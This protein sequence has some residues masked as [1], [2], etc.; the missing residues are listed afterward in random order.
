MVWVTGTSSPEAGWLNVPAVRPGRS[1]RLAGHEG[2]EEVHHRSCPARHGARLCRRHYRSGRPPRQD[3]RQPGRRKALSI[4]SP[5]ARHRAALELVCRRDSRDGNRRVA[6]RRVEEA[7]D[8]VWA[9]V[10]E[11]RRI[12]HEGLA[13]FVAEDHDDGSRSA[14]A[15]TDKFDMGGRLARILDLGRDRSPACERLA[16]RNLQDAWPAA[17]ALALACR[18]RSLARIAEHVLISG[19]ESLIVGTTRPF[20]HAA[21]DFSLFRTR[22]VEGRLLGEVIASLPRS[23]A[24]VPSALL[25]GFRQGVGD[26]AIELSWRLLRCVRSGR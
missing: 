17:S 3:R 10:A 20:Q 9:E 21:K 19:D 14:A 13:A 11:A 1:R 4:A 12:G 25:R 22:L 18:V 24:V 7:A 6:L 5:C 2:T 16:A 23:R 15:W 26:L 8:P